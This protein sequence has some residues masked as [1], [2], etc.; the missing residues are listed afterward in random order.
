MYPRSFEKQSSVRMSIVRMVHKCAHVYC[1]HGP[2]LLLPYLLSSLFAGIIIHICSTA[3]SW[4]LYVMIFKLVLDE[5]HL[6]DV[7]SLLFL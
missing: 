4:Q 2:S 1:S 5:I 3:S 6:Y 7:G